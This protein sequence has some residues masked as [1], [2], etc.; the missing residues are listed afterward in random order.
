[1]KKNL[2]SVTLFW[3]GRRVD[4]V[5]QTGSIFL[6][7]NMMRQ[8]FRISLKLKSTKPEFERATSSSRK[9]NEKEKELKKELAAFEAK[10]EAILSRLP[11]PSKDNFIRLFKS[12]TE[13]FQFNKTSIKIFFDKKIDEA[14]SEE[15]VGTY[16]YY[17]QCWN[18]LE[19]Y[20]PNL[21]F[22]E[23]NEKWLKNYQ[24][25]LK[26]NGNANATVSLRLRCL[27]IMFNEAIRSGFISEKYYPFKN[28]S[29]GSTVKSK[30]VLYPVQLKKLWEYKPKTLRES[31]A[32][33]YWFFCYFS[34]GINFK[35]MAYL[36]WKN[37]NG[38][39]LT[40]IRQK[41]KRTASGSKEIRVHI[42][43][44]MKKIITDWK[45]RNSNAEDYVFPIIKDLTDCLE[46]EKGVIKM[47]RI[48][49][50]KLSAIGKELGFEVHLCLNLARHSFATMLKISGTP[51]AFISDAMGHATSTTTEH[52]LKSI[53]DENMEQ[54][55]SQLL[56][57][58]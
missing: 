29:T 56:S 44:E 50:K 41:T 3:D 51:I 36:Q 6:T 26:K 54:L 7:V 31:R 2:Y 4:K 57:F 13:L 53:P 37:L 22:E 39:T 38:D 35:D 28:I 14:L 5:T 52:Y 21:Y 1:M 20:S 42:N 48:C 27:K 25:K 18:S 24:L 17:K 40:F 46:M 49:N 47:K 11:N 23:I 55:S 58:L 12:E 34:N 10:G 43:V 19:K 33:A 45:N 16:K 9:L 8:Q 15:R 30:S 32:K